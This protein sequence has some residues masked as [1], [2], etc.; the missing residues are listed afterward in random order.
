MTPQFG[1]FTASELY[2]P[3]CKRAQPV[4]EKLLLVL[5][6]GE[7]HEFLCVGCGSSLAK[8]TSSGPAVSAPAPAPPRSSARRRP[9]LG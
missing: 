3:K 9:L 8:R 5:P 7:L 2:C 4:R 6:S 1:A